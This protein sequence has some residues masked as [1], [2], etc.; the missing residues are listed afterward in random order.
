MALLHST[1]DRAIPFNL[2][3]KCGIDLA[4]YDLVGRA[5][6]IPIH[7]VAGGRRVDR[8]PLTAALGLG[9]RRGNRRSCEG[10]GLH[11]GFR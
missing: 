9:T 4:A 11:R 2:M 1:M 6:G 8:V 3:A 10:T 7:L 5:D